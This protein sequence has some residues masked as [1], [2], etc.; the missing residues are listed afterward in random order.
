VDFGN[1][2]DGRNSL[3]RAI[4]TPESQGYSAD[5]I[6]TRSLSRRLAVCLAALATL[7]LVGAGRASA[8]YGVAP[9][10][11]TSVPVTAGSTGAIASPSSLDLVVYLDAED[12]A[13][14]VWVSESPAVGPTGSPA[15]GTLASCSGSS[16]LPFGEPNKWVCRVSTI[17]MQPGRTYY[18]WL[19]FRRQDPGASVSTARISGPFGFS[20]VQQPATPPAIPPAV[21]PANQGPQS[22]VSTK[23]V[24]SAARLPGGNRFDGRRSIKHVPLTTL[25]YRT[26][27]ALGL[28]RQLA[29]ACWN[30]ADWLSVLAAE[31]GA[32]T[33]GDLELQ[34]FWLGRQPRW[35][36]LAP[37]V[38]TDVQGL[39][40]TK[41]ANARRAG[42]VATVIHET[43]HAYGV[44]NE[45]Q[46]NCYAV[47]LVPGFGT[48]LGLGRSRA[49]Y[50]G[51]LARNYV[52]SRS[53]AGYW[54]ASSCRDGGAWDLFESRSL[55]G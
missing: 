53:P 46:T 1:H 43:L 18:W 50:M 22:G 12:S 29:F 32:P 49:A 26:M 35:L 51:T 48:A 9:G 41:V 54:N 6:A 33:N 23:T 45:A 5:V 10:N 2:L 38:C 3:G 34:G 55:G 21:P 25:V 52:R 24:D 19:D 20:L 4:R 30:K 37:H 8:G 11:G 15:A 27:K 36:H 17:R 31:G 44:R 40:S 47:Q 7:G 28:P 14:L 42:A 39:L 13:P 16:L